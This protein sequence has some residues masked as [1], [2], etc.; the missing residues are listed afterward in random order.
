MRLNAGIVALPRAK[1]RVRISAVQD[2]R[3]RSSS[4]HF[5][6]FLSLS[7]LL[8]CKLATCWDWSD[9]LLFQSSYSSEIIWLAY[10]FP[11]VIGNST[12]AVLHTSIRR[13]ETIVGAVS[14]GNVSKNLGRPNS[15]IKTSHL[16]EILIRISFIY[17]SFCP[18][19]DE[20]LTRRPW[21]LAVLMNRIRQW[22]EE[23][24]GFFF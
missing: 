4:G 3:D 1:R 13:I 12:C 17:N 23:N 22:N 24:V 9:V 11:N 19:V 14:I 18:P 16:I 15:N 5:R 10:Q 7:A 6:L 2:V 20:F 21:S 8:Q